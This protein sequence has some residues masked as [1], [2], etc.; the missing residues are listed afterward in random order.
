MILLGDF[1]IFKAGDETSKVIG[2][3]GFKVNPK[4]RRQRQMGAEIRYLIK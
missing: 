1:N 4:L 2:F 3:A